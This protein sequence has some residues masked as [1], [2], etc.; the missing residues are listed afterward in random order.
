MI[1]EICANSYASAYNAEKAGAHRIELCS[2]L[3]VGGITP[4]FGL[5]KQVVENLKI[6]VFVLIRPRSG[7]FTYSDVEFDIMKKDIALSKELGCQGIVSGVLNLDHTIDVTRTKELIECAKPL[8]FVYH[9]AFD[10]VPDVFKALQDLID[11]GVY[12]VLTSGQKMSALT[13]L[14]ILKKLKN[15]AK[16]DISILPGGGITIENA[17]KFK[18][19]GFNEIHCS[20]T[21]FKSSK[22]SPKIKMNSDTHFDETRLGISDLNKIEA[23][24]KLIS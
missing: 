7:N 23:L 8:S 2:E 3:A 10:W 21:E 12:R 16:D 1:V 11:I 18:Q 22:Y 9:R 6:P 19:A 24:L 5:L 20:L 14:E 4:S 13:G 15:Y 17:I